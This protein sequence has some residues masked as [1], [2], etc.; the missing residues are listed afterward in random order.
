M[1]V[2]EKMRLNKERFLENTRT[3]IGIEREKGNQEVKENF[4]KNTMIN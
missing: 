3:E 4:N 1:F 2:K